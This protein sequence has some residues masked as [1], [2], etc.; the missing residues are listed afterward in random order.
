M[1]RTAFQALNQ[2]GGLLGIFFT[3]DEHIGHENVIKFCHRPFADTDE[4]ERE[5]TARHNAR[6]GKGDLDT[7]VVAYAFIL[8]SV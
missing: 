8:N 7:V 1:F 4:M 5:L 2:H 6:V 3:A